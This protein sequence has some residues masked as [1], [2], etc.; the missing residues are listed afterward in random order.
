[1]DQAKHNG[2]G[3]RLREAWNTLMRAL[4]GLD[5]NP[6]EDVIERLD[7]LERGLYVGG[8]RQSRARRDNG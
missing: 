6:M 3:M 8:A 1:M 7:Q 4:D 2:L 5:R